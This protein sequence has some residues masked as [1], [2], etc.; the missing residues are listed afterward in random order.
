MRALVSWLGQSAITLLSLL[1]TTE[2]WNIIDIIV[3]QLQPRP[4]HGEGCDV[5]AEQTLQQLINAVRRVERAE[6]LP[7]YDFDTR[8]PAPWI[9]LQQKSIENAKSPSALILMKG[10]LLF[11]W[12]LSHLLKACL[13]VACKLTS[14]IIVGYSDGKAAH[15]IKNLIKICQRDF[16][17]SPSSTAAW[18]VALGFKLRRSTW[19]SRSC[20]HEGL[21]RQVRHNTEY[22]KSC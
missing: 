11:V 12:Y 3:L 5:N 9:L 18:S 14:F 4:C 10:K 1:L 6:L 17:F 16:T 20:A 15:L 13:F 19:P 22:V 2:S 7:A 21:C 8:T